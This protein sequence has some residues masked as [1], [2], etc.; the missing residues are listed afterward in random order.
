MNRNTLLA[1]RR[2]VLA[3][4]TLAPLAT[5]VGAADAWPSRPVTIVHPYAAGGPAD[6][7]A[8]VLGQQ[9]ATRFGQTF[10][11]DGRSGGAATIGT[12]SVARSQPDGH[13]L[14]LGT[15]GGHVVTPL[16]QKTP[17]DGIADFAFIGVVAIQPNVLVVHPSLGID[18]VAALIDRARSQPG[19]LNFAS[20]GMGGATHL[21]LEAFARAA[22]IELTH[23]PYRG[24]APAI[25]DLLGGQVQMAM[26][27]LA[28][29]RGHI[30][31]GKLKALAYGGPRRTEL[32]PGVPTLAELGYA[33]TAT[34]TWYTLSAP[35]QTPPTVVQALHG[36]LHDL[37]SAPDYRK[38]MSAFGAELL[39]LTP[40]QTT[41]FVKEDQAAMH[42]LLGA[43][44]LLAR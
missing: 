8:R 27:N 25:T 2:Q 24:A 29:T 42:K 23:V 16:M 10:L 40:A 18:S 33:N 11:V 41:A 1:S 20:A 38:A 30:A 9:L 31:S 28:A 3:A 22:G 7:M 36:A 13:T 39:D 15:S 32:L 6:A 5:M 21:G 26:L 43:L 34:S 37:A 17:Y 35:R 19:K 44:N 14:L 4:F 12:G